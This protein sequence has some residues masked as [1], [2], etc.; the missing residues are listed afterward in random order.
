M[1]S[2]KLLY[3]RKKSSLTQEALAE[4]FAVSRQSIQK[5]ENG[6][7]LPDLE[8]ITE[9]AD[10]FSVSVD[11]LL[12]RPD[13]R[14]TEEMRI[15]PIPQPSFEK[16][17]PW[18]VYSSDLLVELRQSYEE[19]KDTSS[20]EK[21]LRE[22]AA[23]PA[24]PAKEKLADTLFSMISSLPTR[25][26]YNYNEPD[27]YDS[28]Y[29]LSSHGYTPSKE[30]TDDELFDKVKGAWQGRVSGC[31]LGKTVEGIRLS[32]FIPFLKRTNNYP[33]HRYISI[34]DI[35]DEN[36]AGMSYPMKTR[37]YADALCG[38]APFDDD[39]N[40][41]TLGLMLIENRGKDFTSDDVMWLWLSKQPKDAYCTA[42]RVAF[43]N[44]IMGYTPHE[45]AIYK[46]PYREWIGAQI[47][48]DFFGYVNPGNPVLAAEMAHR[49][50]RISHVKNGIYGEMFA[51]ALIAAAFCEDDMLK[52]VKAGLN[53]IPSTSRL[54]EK[55]S[56]LINGYESGLSCK[57]TFDN[58][59]K[60]WDDRDAHD[61]CHTISNALIV[62]ASLLYGGR[63]FGKTIC[64]AVEAGFDTD[65]N[66]ATCGSVIGAMNGFESIPEEWTAPLCGA[67]DTS[68][69]GS[70]VIKIDDAARRTVKLIKNS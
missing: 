4:K 10:F 18:D 35:T 29:K 68:I 54:H 64:L 62:A 31:M 65:C 45:S 16:F 8:R 1:F 50:A 27:D 47:R 53:E 23:L 25:E 43:R 24:S 48:G 36:I 69:I 55:L 30:L 56:D 2:D 61:W 5:W 57:E 58:I 42:E 60:K 63:D 46:N 15:S 7:A 17:H 41:T 14:S 9:I 66:G 70:G 3:L 21:L 44:F 11:Y 26:D 51:S 22:I 32:E 28:I 33:M 37:A 34:S 52:V 13:M 67:F 20:V 6:K 38:S 12:D 40:Y 59:Y 49:D 39:T 19:G